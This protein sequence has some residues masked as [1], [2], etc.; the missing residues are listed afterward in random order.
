MRGTAIPGFNC[1][2]QRYYASNY[3]R[4]NTADQYMASAGPSDPVSWN[5][6][7]YVGGDPVNRADPTG[8]RW[9]LCASAADDGPGMSGCVDAAEFA[10]PTEMQGGGGGGGF[11]IPTYSNAFSQ[12]GILNAQAALKQLAKSN[13]A[14][15]SGQL[16]S[17]A[18][19]AS[20]PF[21]V[22]AVQTEAAT[23]ANYVYDGASSTVAWNTADF[24]AASPGVTTVG[25][26]FTGPYGTVS[27]SQGDGHAIFVRSAL[28]GSSAA[29]TVGFGMITVLPAFNSS[30]GPTNYALAAMLHEVLHKFG[31]GDADLETALGVAPGDVLA[32]GST[33]VTNAL[34]KDCFGGH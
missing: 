19:I 3:G 31:L 2:D 25:Q 24:G 21:T 7:A 11:L 15:C 9:V 32:Y 16:N 23:D 26:E 17:I 30:S 22:G 4:F 6:Y 20:Q 8:Q 34:Y 12:A 29:T 33:T 14:P 27:L 18:S 10:G 1:A 5:R 28:W 13:L